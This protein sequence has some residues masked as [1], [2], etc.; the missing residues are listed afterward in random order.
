M[1]TDQSNRHIDMNP[2]V[3]LNGIA[4]Q[5]CLGRQMIQA[6]SGICIE[7]DRG[8]FVAVTGPSGSGKSTLLSIIGCLDRPSR[9]H[10]FLNGED[11]LALG[12]DRLAT[13]R[14]ERLGFVFQSFNLLP[15]LNA[16]ENVALPLFYRRKPVSGERNGER[17]I[18]KAVLDR[19]GLGHRLYHVPSQLSGGEQ[20]RVAIARAIVNEPDL[21]LADEPTGALDTSTRDGILSLLSGLQ[22]GGLTVLLVTHDAEVASRAQRV[23]R[24][25]DGIV[26]VDERVAAHRTR[27][28]ILGAA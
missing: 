24:L 4:K 21:L 15:R 5:H 14:N 19:V 1:R 25:R 8:E 18:A 13:L 16:M 12:R 26:I 6:L 23:I 28:V 22:S 9:G 11:I 3:K 20:Q 17:N 10:Y 27:P 7:I 2:L